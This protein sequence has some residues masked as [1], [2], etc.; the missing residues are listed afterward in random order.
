MRPV[1][2]EEERRRRLLEEE[3]LRK[4]R[5]EQRLLD[6]HREMLRARMLK[7]QQN[8]DNEG[9]KKDLDRMDGGGQR[10]PTDKGVAKDP[11]W[12]P[13]DAYEDAT[14]FGEENVEKALKEYDDMKEQDKDD[15]TQQKPKNDE[16]PWGANTSPGKDQW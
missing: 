12:K 2:T 1:E 11:N 3:R 15:M 13:Y 14:K 9:D 7:E 6:A 16:T 5:E 10:I 8:K 4:E